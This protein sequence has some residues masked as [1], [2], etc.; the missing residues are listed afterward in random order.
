MN[1]L[2]VSVAAAA[3][4]LNLGLLIGLFFILE[5]CDWKLFMVSFLLKIGSEFLLL[6]SVAGFMKKKKLLWLLLP[7][8]LYYC[9]YVVIIGATSLFGTYEWKG[10]RTR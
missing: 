3:Y 5:G 2:A 4:L 8:Q 7:A 6:N 9:I 10:R 1:G